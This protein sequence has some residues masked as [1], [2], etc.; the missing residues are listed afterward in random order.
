MGNGENSET[1]LLACV[2]VKPTDTFEQACTQL[3][4][5]MVIQQHNHSNT[6]YDDLPVY[7]MCTD[8]IDY[9]FMTLTQDK[10][11]HKSRL[12]TRSKTDD[13]KII[14]SYLV[15]LLQKIVEDVEIREPKSKIIHQGADY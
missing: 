6:T 10:V 13:S 4:L 5:Y 15:G 8:G 11:I 12:F 9:I 3:M 7:G 2:M 14:F 1:S